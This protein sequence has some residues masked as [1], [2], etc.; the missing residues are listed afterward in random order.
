MIP[1]L[2]EAENIQSALRSLQ[3]LRTR[4][5]EIILVDGGSTDRTAEL[6]APLADR[7]LTGT[8]GRAPQMNR[9]AAAAS[10]EILLFLHADTELPADCDRLIAA[11]L[12]PAEGWGR[13][14]VQLSGQRAMFTLISF[15]INLRSRLTGIATGDQAIFVSRALFERTGGF[16][17]IALMED[18][19]LSRRLLGHSRPHCLSA[20]VVTSSRRW[21]QNGIIKTIF[22]MWWLRLRYFLGADPDKLAK[23]YD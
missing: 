23:E 2:N 3:T 22:K 21:E 9:G 12:A 18:I 10:G 11:A 16:P 4:G 14:D 7:I 8:R 15:C 19:A 13:F 5:D 17:P 20:R 1:A 6:A